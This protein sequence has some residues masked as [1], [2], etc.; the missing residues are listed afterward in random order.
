MQGFGRRTFDDTGANDILYR[1]GHSN[2]YE[3]PHARHREALAQ[4]YDRLGDDTA[5]E[6]VNWFNAV[7]DTYRAELRTLNELNFARFDAKMEQRMAELRAGMS[8]MKAELMRWIFGLWATQLL[9]M[10]GMFLTLWRRGG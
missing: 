2:A 5:T 1:V 4:F 6:L 8:E 9:A 3:R 7:D 10:A